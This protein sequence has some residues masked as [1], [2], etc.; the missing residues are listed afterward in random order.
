[1]PDI[2]IKKIVNLD[3]GASYPMLVHIFESIYPDCEIITVNSKTQFE[4]VEYQSI[5]V[6]FSI[7]PIGFCDSIRKMI[8]EALRVLRPKGYLVIAYDRSAP[9]KDSIIC[10]SSSFRDSIRDCYREL[11][12]MY[13]WEYGRIDDFQPHIEQD[14]ILETF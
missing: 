6:F 4:S 1:M 11:S 12:N 9:T 7:G 13:N 10:Y 3:I 2:P 8:I 5:D 14:W